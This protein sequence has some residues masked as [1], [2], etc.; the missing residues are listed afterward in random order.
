MIMVIKNTK[1]VTL[2]LK[3]MGKKL[4]G[5]KEVKSG[6]YVVMLTISYMDYMLVG[7]RMDRRRWKG[8]G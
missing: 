3:N 5:M 2:I 1:Q 4:F 8:S 6:G 7:I